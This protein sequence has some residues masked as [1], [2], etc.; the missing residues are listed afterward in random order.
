MIWVDKLALLVWLPVTLFAI[1]VNLGPA[2]ATSPG[3]LKFWFDLS[4]MTVLPLWVTL[5]LG[6]LIIFGLPRTGGKVSGLGGDRRSRL[7]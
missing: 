5:R 1:A 4:L 6:H 7:P 2:P 3:L